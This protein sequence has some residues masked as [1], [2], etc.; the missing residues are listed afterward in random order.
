VAEFGD[1]WTACFNPGPFGNLEG[2]NAAAFFEN[3]E[4]A[5]EGRDIESEVEGEGGGGEYLY[6]RESSLR[7]DGCT[8][9]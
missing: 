7:G 8:A 2:V 1:S 3:S 5:G 4:K 6:L 9:I